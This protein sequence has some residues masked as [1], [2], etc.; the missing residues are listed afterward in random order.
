MTPA[1]RHI[2]PE[3]IAARLSHAALLSPVRQAM[4]AYSTGKASAAAQVLYPAQGA[5]VHV[6]SAVLPGA[7]AS[8]AA[9]VAER[10]RQGLETR[11]FPSPSGAFSVTVS[12]GVAQ[13]DRAEEES[14]RALYERADK[15]LYQAKT[16]GRNRVVKAA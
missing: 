10:I 1:P 5:D 9:D 11:V 3:E 16:S 15:A 2:G 6:K 7:P 14:T 13:L 4:I 8:V 12:S